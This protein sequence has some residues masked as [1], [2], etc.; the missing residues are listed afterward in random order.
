MTLSYSDVFVPERD[1]TLNSMTTPSA[2]APSRAEL[3][4]LLYEAAELEHTLMC[5]YLYAAFSMRDGESEGLSR[6]EAVAVARWRRTILS[7]A[8]E[9]MGHL[10]AVWNIT[11]ALG[12]PPQ[13][14]RGNFPLDPGALPAGIVVRL[15]PFDEA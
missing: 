2:T 7:V 4:Y 9:E 1:G 15:A 6:E 3:I 8:V 14:T 10:A 5:T 13:F 12:G 11:S